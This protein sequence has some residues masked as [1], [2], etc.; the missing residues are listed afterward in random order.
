MT[1]ELSRLRWFAAGLLV[2][3]TACSDSGR[4]GAAKDPDAGVDAAADLDSAGIDVGGSLQEAGVAMDSRMVTVT[5]NES[6]FV[7]ETPDQKHTFTATVTGAAT[8]TV[9]WSSSNTYIATVDATGVVT[10]VS[11]GEA[12]ITATS[13]VDTTKTA[14]ARISVSEPNRPR[15]TS[16][17]DAKTITAGPIGII[18]CGDSLMRTYAANASDQT[19][20]GQVLD[21]FLSADAA[22]DNTLSNGGRSSRSFYN[23]VGRWDLVKTRLAAAKSAGKPTFV[24]IMFGHNDQKKTTDTDGALYLTFASQNPNGTVAGTFYDYLERYVVEVRA[25]GGIPVLFTPFVRQYLAG[26]PQTLAPA[27]Q[28]NITAPY[29][30]ETT[31]RGDYP[32]AMKAVAA[33]HDVPMVDITTW[34][35]AL[36]E[37]RAAAGTLAYLYIS[38][39]QTHVRNLGALL[40]AQEAVR[41]LNAQGILVGYAKA[42]SARVMLDAGT[43]GFGGLY[44][45]NTIDKSFR[46]S[47]FGDATGTITLTAPAGYSLSTDGTTFAS[48]AAIPCDASYSGSMVNVRFAPTDATAYNGDLMV[49]HTSIVP[50]YGNTVANAKAGAISLTGNGKAAVAGGAPAAATWAMFSGTT[51]TL[52]ATT[53]GPIS[54]NQATITGLVNKNVLNGGA[55]FD[56]P[57]GTWPAESARNP[58]RHIEFSVPITTGTFT[59]DSVSVGGGSGGGSNMRWDIVYSLTPDFTMPTALETAISGAKDTLVTSNYPSLGVA[60]SAGQ[61]LYLRLYPYNTTAAASGKSIM[62]AN[63]VVSGITG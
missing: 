63:V 12:V 52:A 47:P 29:T 46:I 53:D 3:F 31:A 22:V 28:H 25:L 55:R 14:A 27:G 56:S 26:S 41:A 50:D 1:K 43:L 9:T 7:F 39:D 57:D 49:A 45:G 5:L 44:A 2:L 54:A 13:T 23:E 24:F 21:Q 61:T 59:L 40:M 30:G 51:I 16:Y 35:K 17:L 20:W 48:Q 33:K 15:A 4:S 37:A 11:G 58:N 38:G 62:V 32:A 8:T 60:I 42:P 34:S 10:S 6:T 18:M 36:V 19:G